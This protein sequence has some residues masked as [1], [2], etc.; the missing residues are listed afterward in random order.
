MSTWK[1]HPVYLTIIEILQERNSITDE[2]LLEM[3]KA[4]YKEIGID[5]LNRSLMRM[6]IAGLIYV[7]SL[8]KGR[9][10]I[11]LRER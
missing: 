8:T 3:L 1:I 2:E 6:E 11:Q 9:R 10:L 4:F 5:D 7:S